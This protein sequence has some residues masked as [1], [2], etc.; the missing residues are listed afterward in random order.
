[1]LLLIVLYQYVH[2]MHKL[3]CAA[4][5]YLHAYDCNRCYWQRLLDLRFSEPLDADAV[6]DV[7]D[8]LKLV[9]YSNQRPLVIL[10]K[11]C[12]FYRGKYY[13]QYCI[14]K[15]SAYT[16]TYYALQHKQV[17]IE[18]HLIQRTVCSTHT[19]YRSSIQYNSQY[20]LND[21]FAVS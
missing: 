12:N 15:N 17:S 5:Y 16:N 1:M 2:Y 8:D 7:I 4:V 19:G 18:C 3:H 6:P 9:S 20:S 11:P 10:K 21:C 13:R 14:S